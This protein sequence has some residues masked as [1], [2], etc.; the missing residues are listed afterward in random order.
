MEGGKGENGDGNTDGNRESWPAGTELG[1][2]RRIRE[3]G[4][5]G[6]GRGA[7]GKTRDTSVGHADS[8]R[9]SY[10]WEGAN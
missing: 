7:A 4:A 8:Y 1:R 5:S 2:E 9:T 6:G 3:A 10:E